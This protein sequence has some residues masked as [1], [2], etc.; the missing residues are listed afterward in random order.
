MLTPSAAS[1]A[2]AASAVSDKQA[3]PRP[4]ASAGAVPLPSHIG[5]LLTA[6][7]ISNSS[8]WKRLGALLAFTR[9]F[10]LKQRSKLLKVALTHLYDCQRKCPFLAMNMGLEDWTWEWSI[11][12]QAALGQP[13]ACQTLQAWV[14][15]RVLCAVPR[16][17]Q[18]E[19]NWLIYTLI[20]KRVK[21]TPK[22]WYLWQE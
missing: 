22:I 12:S 5:S 8:F 2:S 13:G 3:F 14:Y 20:K 15:V 1:A 11:Q 9:G 18:E 16:E 17:F 19:K 7:I 10:P 4:K 21:M 6:S